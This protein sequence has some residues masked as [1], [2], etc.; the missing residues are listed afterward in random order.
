MGHLYKAK[1]SN[2]VQSKITGLITFLILTCLFFYFPN[3]A[4]ASASSSSR[5]F[6]CHAKKNF[7]G[8]VIHPPVARGNC[9]VCHNPH[10]SKFKGLLR[11]KE[12]DLCYRCHRKDKKLFAEGIEHEPVRKGNCLA[13]HSPHAS[14]TANLIKGRIA[15][16]C[17]ACHK[18]LKRHFKY[19]HPP[20]QKGKCIIC[21][22]PHH[23]DNSLLL[24][25]K[26]DT[27]CF[28]CHKKAKMLKVHV[29][30]PVK[31]KIGDCLSCHNPH[32]SSS[33]YLMRRFLHEPYKKNCSICHGASGKVTASK[34]LKC[35]K[36]ISHRLLSIHNHLLGAHG[37]GCIICHSPHAGDT[38]NLLRAPQVLL[39]R[40]CHE[41]TYERH[42]DSLYVHPDINNCANCH[43]VHGSSRL[44]M[45]QQDG[46]K[47]CTRCHKEQGKFTH[48]IGPNIRDPRTG[49]EMTCVT[50]HHPM[51]TNY[52]NELKLS[53]K[54][55]LC[56][57]CHRNYQ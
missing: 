8:R 2:A 42:Q 15:D 54:E 50:C 33:K 45:L 14:N 41:D 22:D 25:A 49:Q 38:K 10:C 19:S 57:Q 1:R 13:C 46:N 31:N 39:C 9:I 26:A 52:K 21:H 48:P 44:A 47:V 17:F 11:Y 53:G 24:R 4:R 27:I 29:G 18:N 43:Q 3:M 35:H 37:N 55:D 51:G 6:K 16:R 12:A 30:F 36:D 7:T 34:C 20:F 40:K 23:A 28:S 5:C 32:G 56:I